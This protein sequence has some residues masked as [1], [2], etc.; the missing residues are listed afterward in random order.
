MTIAND[1]AETEVA[2]TKCVC[3]RTST[4][5]YVDRFSFIYINSRWLGFQVDVTNSL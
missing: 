3:L 5:I 4:K 2:E 1:A